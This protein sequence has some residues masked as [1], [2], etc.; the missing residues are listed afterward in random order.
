MRWKKECISIC[1]T[2]YISRLV[3]LKVSSLIH[4][5]NYFCQVRCIIRNIVRDWAA[6]VLFY[7]SCFDSSFGTYRFIVIIFT[8]VNIP[9]QKV[10]FLK[11][12]KKKVQG[13]EV[14]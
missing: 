11:I 7:F 1:S 2:F 14:M 9:I 4:L 5:G 12:V 8:P 3:V 6:E 13:G 10:N